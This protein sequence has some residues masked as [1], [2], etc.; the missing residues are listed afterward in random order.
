MASKSFV[1]RGIVP[2]VPTPFCPGGD[3]DWAALAGLIDFASAAG[4]C[5]VCL[6]AYAS[7]FYKLTAAEHERAI[8]TAIEAARGRIP[9]IGQVNT[10][11]LARARELA[12]TIAGMGADAVNVAVPRLFA[13]GETNLYRFF[14]A[15]LSRI[16]LPLVIQ[17]FNPGG[18]SIG[19]DFIARLH[20]EFPHFRYVKLEEPMM[21]AKVRAI[22]EATADG[23]GVIEGWGGM[24]MPEL[25]PAGIC[26]V[27]PG[28]A[29]ADILRA[30]WDLAHDGQPEQAFD[31]FADVLPQIVYSLQNMEFFHHAEKLLLVA[32]GVLPNALVRDATLQ[33]NADE[34]RHVDF[35][36]ARVL[37]LLDRMGL[38]RNPAMA[39]PPAK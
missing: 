11:S 34:R 21:S 37:R 14:D 22:R 39:G 16:N 25:I 12:A 28:L 31:V 9:V 30:A 23:V 32:R 18:P 35:L 20:R 10:P 7:E 38:A 3:P 5:A 33:L 4:M 36:N 27:M 2:I 19:V 17:D 29:V 13:I 1:I 6:P 8:A 15:V 24:C 26:G